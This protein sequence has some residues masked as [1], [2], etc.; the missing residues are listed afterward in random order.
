MK[1]VLIA[2]DYHPISE[3]VAE[4]GYE[5]AKNLNAEVCLL[6]VL[7]D[8]GFYGTQ[9]PTFMGYDGYSGMAPDL[10]LA[11]EMRNIAEEFMGKA[12]AH[13]NDERVSTY[14][15]EGDTAKTILNYAEEWGAEVLVMGTHSH[16]TFEKLLL[17]TVAGKILEKTKTPLYLIP[18]KK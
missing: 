18:I 15:A 12:K 5:L 11:L 8:V 4:A 13:L 1:K 7:N 9:Y 2:I 10:D 14:I 3:K 17:G 6:H 16:S